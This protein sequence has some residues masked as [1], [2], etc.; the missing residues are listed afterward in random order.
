MN[1]TT[2]NSTILDNL[3]LQDDQLKVDSNQWFDVITNPLFYGGIIIFI[4]LLSCVI[5]FIFILKSRKCFF[6]NLIRLFVC[7]I[8]FK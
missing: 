7:V 1:S 2:L 4:I 8:D 6:C 3:T 5:I